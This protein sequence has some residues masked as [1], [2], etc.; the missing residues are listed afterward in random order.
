MVVRSGL[1]WPFAGLWPGESLRLAPPGRWRPDADLYETASAV[2]VVV[3]LAGMEEDEIE[4]QLFDD[5]LVVAGRRHLPASAAEG[6]YH[7]ASI[8]QGPFLLELPLPAPVDADRVEARYDR[9]LLRITLPK[10]A[11]DG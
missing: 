2:E 8:R 9:G 5:V 4:A 10:R 6:R 3:D 1:E 11:E 7:A